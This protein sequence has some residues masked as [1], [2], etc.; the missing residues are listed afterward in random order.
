MSIEKIPSDAVKFKTQWLLNVD[1]IN[2]LEKMAETT[3][4]KVSFDSFGEWKSSCNEI[5]FEK[6][7]RKLREEYVQKLVLAI[8]DLDIPKQKELHEQ[9]AH[10]R[11]IEDFYK[12]ISELK[13]ENKKLREEIGNL[14]EHIKV[15][16]NEEVNRRLDGLI[17]Q[18][19]RWD[20]KGGAK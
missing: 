18:M 2:K 12:Q 16:S 15:V 1:F 10:H 4:A 17:A 9:I 20:V 13:K 5:E 19:I 3:S 6:E 7:L 8:E 14:K 11:R